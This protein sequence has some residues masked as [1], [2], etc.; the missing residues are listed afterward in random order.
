MVAIGVPNGSTAAGSDYFGWV[1]AADT[2]TIR[3]GNYN[4]T[5]SID[6]AAGTFRAMVI[7]FLMDAFRRD[8]CGFFGSRVDFI[9]RNRM[10]FYLSTG[11]VDIPSL[12][13]CF[14]CKR[15]Y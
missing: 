5:G 8:V 4:N 13:L 9:Q 1:S 15:I 3:F 10:V 6:P 12:Y 11:T 2:V 14:L 7:K